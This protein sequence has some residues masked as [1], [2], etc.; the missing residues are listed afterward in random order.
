MLC[1]FKSKWNVS[2]F[3]GKSYQV[4]DEEMCLRLGQENS[5]LKDSCSQ[6]CQNSTELC[7]TLLETYQLKRAPLLGENGHGIFKPALLGENGHG[8]LK[9]TTQGI[10]FLKGSCKEFETPYCFWFLVANQTSKPIE[11]TEEPV[12]IVEETTKGKQ[13]WKDFQSTRPAA[14]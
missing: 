10:I 1:F 8:I 9:T 6:F 13:D 14:V 11:L 3:S 7:L 12:K 5:K 2:K 4:K